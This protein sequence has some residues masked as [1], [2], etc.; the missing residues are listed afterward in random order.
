MLEF[1]GHLVAVRSWLRVGGRRH[2]LGAVDG[3]VVGN[4]R[5]HQFGHNH[6]DG[7][8]VHHHAPAV[9]GGDPFPN[10]FI[11]RAGVAHQHFVEL[12]RGVEAVVF[13]GRFG[14]FGEV[15]AVDG[16]VVG[17]TDQFERVD[18]DVDTLVHHGHVAAVV[19]GG[20]LAQNFVAR[21]GVAQ[22]H[23]AELDH[24]VIGAVVGGG[25]GRRIGDAEAVHGDVAR[26]GRADQYGGF[27][28][29]DEEV[30]RDHGFVA[31]QIDGGPGAEHQADEAVFD[32]VAVG[33]DEVLE[34]KFRNAA[35]IVHCLRI[36][37]AVERHL[38]QTA[39]FERVAVHQSDQIGV[40]EGDRGRHGVDLGDGLLVGGF[41]PAVV[42]RGIGAGDDVRTA[43]RR[44]IGEG[45]I[46]IGIAVVDHFELRSRHVGAEHRGVRRHGREDR[47]ALIGEGDGLSHGRLVAA[48][49][50]RHEGAHDLDAVAA[51]AVHDRNR[52]G[53]QRHVHIGVEIIGSGHGRN[54]GGTIGAA[55][56]FV[57][58]HL[59]EGGRGGVFEAR[60]EV[61]DGLPARQRDGR[62]TL[63]IDVAVVVGVVALHGEG[64]H[65][66]VRRGEGHG[67]GARRHIHEGVCPVHA[68]RLG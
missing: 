32:A 66:L 36:V 51:R 19:L 52:I 40:D 11:L 5:E 39:E 50:G 15:V 58:Q 42:R 2:G 60:V 57:H 59:V 9:V 41:V 16:E 43:A 24:D 1:H 37:D 33:H 30:D 44:Q 25:H 45:H 7:L 49:V 47:R 64:R 35:A 20:P 63:R 46:H 23:F 13:H 31:A 65:E 54:G 17:D 3:Q 27:V 22:E 67:V 14:G 12:D 29:I 48:V 34:G 53:G 55:C 26:R 4:A 38:I 68:R 18:F 21:A 8:L 61:V 56:R 6:S 10:D 28:V 62:L